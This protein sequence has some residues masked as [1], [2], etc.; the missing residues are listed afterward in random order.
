MTVGI[1]AV[2]SNLLINGASSIAKNTDD[3]D[4]YFSY[5][6]DLSSTNANY[7]IISS[8]EISFNISFDEAGIQSGYFEFAVTN[9]SSN[10]DASVNVS[11]TG[12]DEYLTITSS[13]YGNLKI[14]P[15]KTTAY[16]DIM[17]SFN[18]SYV[19]DAPLVKEIT[20]SI[21][22]AAIER[23]SQASGTVD[24]PLDP[25]I[26]AFTVGDVE[27]NA[28]YGMTWEEFVD[29]DFNDGK[30]SVYLPDDDCNSDGILFE[31]GCPNR[32]RN[33][34]PSDVIQEGSNY[35]ILEWTPDDCF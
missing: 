7:N 15:A 17:I 9:S 3:F 33:V 1:A 32:V 29:S 6:S 21:D 20:C 13:L 8:D 26:I 25:S 12:S 35:S 14:I 31:E 22:A 27:Y 19:G 11:C 24:S 30:F 23:N 10:Y 18:K 2:S 28:Y 16:G 5:F 4:V 34:L